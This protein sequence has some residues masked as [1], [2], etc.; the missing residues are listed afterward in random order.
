MIP[1]VLGTPTLREAT[2]AVH[3]SRHKGRASLGRR[4]AKYLAAQ[5]AHLLM[6]FR[7]NPGVSDSRSY[8]VA[9]MTRHEACFTSGG[10]GT[11]PHLHV[12]LQP[13]ADNPAFELAAW[14]RTLRCSDWHPVAN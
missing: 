2:G 7:M 10:R 11:A 13:I 8:Y 3:G 5:H 12:L 9:S 6:E 1:P 14:K 4:H